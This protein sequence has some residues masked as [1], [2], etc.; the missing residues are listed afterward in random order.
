MIVEELEKD[1]LKEN[2]ILEDDE[3]AKLVL[4]V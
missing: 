2:T 1:V 3:F 4:K